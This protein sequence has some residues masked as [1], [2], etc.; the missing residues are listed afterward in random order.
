MNSQEDKGQCSSH[1]F[2]MSAEKG[3][4][5]FFSIGK[6]LTFFLSEKR[7][8]LITHKGTHLEQPLLLNLQNP[9]L[10]SIQILLRLTALIVNFWETFQPLHHISL[11]CVEGRKVGRVMVFFSDLRP[12]IQ[13]SSSRDAE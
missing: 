13:D 12:Q 7:T 2:S 10:L 4:T 6:N 8:N 3:C 9:H 1:P 11:R 5:I